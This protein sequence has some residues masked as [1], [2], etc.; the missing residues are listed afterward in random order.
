MKVKCV[1]LS[2]RYIHYIKDGVLSLIVTP[3]YRDFGDIISICIPEKEKNH[4]VSS[5]S[6]NIVTYYNLNIFI[7]ICN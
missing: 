3:T 6:I 4:K 2:D 7:I 5:D 1:H